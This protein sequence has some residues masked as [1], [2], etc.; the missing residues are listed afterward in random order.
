MPKLF[1]KIKKIHDRLCYLYRFFDPGQAAGQPN[2]IL[3]FPKI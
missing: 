2:T 3:G 1:K